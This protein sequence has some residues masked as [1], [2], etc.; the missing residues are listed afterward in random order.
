MANVASTSIQRGSQPATCD[1]VRHERSKTDPHVNRYGRYI[2]R[3]GALAVALGIGA[4]VASAPGMAW[5]DEGTDNNQPVQHDSDPEGDPGTPTS[6]APASQQ[7]DLGEVIRHNLERTTDTLRKVVTGVVRSSGGALTSA[8]HTGRPTPVGNGSE[9]ADQKDGPVDT[10]PPADDQQSPPQQRI[11]HNTQHPAT[12][13]SPT[14]PGAA[15][16]HFSPAATG[17]MTRIRDMAQDSDA[18]L[19]VS[20]PQIV[21]ALTPTPH[22]DQRPAQHTGSFHQPSRRQRA[23]GHRGAPAQSGRA[24]RVRAAGS[25]RDRPGCDE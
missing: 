9:A 6:S 8:H 12:T 7:P 14:V 1:G 22:I 11:S 5:A 23:G 21:S 19:H 20:T 18:A 15:A 25:D 24:R 13:V 17:V 2:G 3:V 16:R 4:A 10:P